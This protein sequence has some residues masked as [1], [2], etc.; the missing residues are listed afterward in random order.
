M[1][2]EAQ[3]TEFDAA[4]YLDSPEMIAAY[5]NA[6]L[7]ENDP[8]ALAEALGQVARAQ[9]MSDLARQAGLSR[10][11]LYRA[12]SGTGSAQL[13]TIMRVLGAMGYT[14]KVAPAGPAEAA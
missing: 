13:D 9:G 12:L 8:A 10:S 5:L 4:A 2:L 6:V 14:L 3:T 11:A 7:G 1:T